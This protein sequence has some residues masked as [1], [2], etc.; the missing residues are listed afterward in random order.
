MIGGRALRA[1]DLLVL[2][3]MFATS[4]TVASVVYLRRDL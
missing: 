3:A 2:G 1:S 4:A